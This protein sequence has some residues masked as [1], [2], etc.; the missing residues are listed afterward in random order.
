MEV[1]IVENFEGGC[2]KNQA[3]KKKTLQ[4]QIV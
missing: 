1:Y 4:Q 3:T 2:I